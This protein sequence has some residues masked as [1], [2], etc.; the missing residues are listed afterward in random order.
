M[1]GRKVGF[2]MTRYS[3]FYR[4]IR[5]IVEKYPLLKP[6]IVG[7]N[8]LVTTMMYTLYAVLLAYL[9][10]VSYHALFRALLVS[11][12]SFLLIS[13]YRKW[14][15]Q[16]RPYESWAITPLI[17]RKGKGESFP[18][19]HVFSA[20]LISMCWLWQS[21]SLG[22]F[23]LLLSLGLAVCRVVAGVHYPKDVLAGYALGLLFGTL[24][25]L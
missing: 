4:K 9:F 14:L 18:S 20:T 15:N 11:G 2:L 21:P 24:L 6:I 23:L 22:L 16:P 12:L 7:Y 5:V 8:G 13:L 19:R 10:L 25:F 17:A 1:V 3:E